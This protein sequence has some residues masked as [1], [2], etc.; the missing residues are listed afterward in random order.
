M[1]LGNFIVGISIFILALFMAQAVPLYLTTI[2]TGTLDLLK[3]FFL[4]IGVASVFIGALT[5]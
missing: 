3:I 2:P 1:A 5:K 4:F